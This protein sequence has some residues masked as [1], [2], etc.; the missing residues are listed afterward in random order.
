MQTTA[1]YGLKKPEGNDTVDI[2]VI[3]G[4]M[5][6]IDMKLKNNAD[7]IGVL[8]E[9]FSS[10]FADNTKQLGEINSN[11]IDLKQFQTI[12]GAYVNG[13]FV[14]GSS[15]SC[16]KFTVV[17]VKRLDGT[18]AL[19]SIL[20]GGTAPNY[21]TRTEKYYASNGTTILN[22]IAFNRSYTTKNKLYKEVKI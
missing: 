4:N 15:D 22:T 3:N 16:D 21:A 9:K 20:S 12:C 11:I 5:D 19:E 1:N 2:D 7:N 17:Q 10:Q 18:L 14:E 8:D 13:A 6:T